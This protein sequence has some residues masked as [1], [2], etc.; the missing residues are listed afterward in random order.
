MSD[1]LIHISSGSDGQLGWKF[2][3]GQAAYGRA[4]SFL[5]SAPMSVRE[6]LC[7]DEA[8]CLLMLTGTFVECRTGLGP[9]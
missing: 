1:C 9:A 7:H 3:F 4:V 8:R 6:V 2:V 5:K